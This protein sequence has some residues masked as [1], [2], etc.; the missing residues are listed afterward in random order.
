MNRISRWEST[1]AALLALVT[2]L[3][4]QGVSVVSP[5]AESGAKLT[6]APTTLSFGNVQI[7]PTQTQSDIP[8][9]AAPVA[10]KITQASAKG[11]GFDGDGGSLSSPTSLRRSATLTVQNTGGLNATIS[12]VTVAGKG[13]KISGIS[14]PWTLRPGQRVSF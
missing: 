4:C 14:T 11:T 6:V 1:I 2:M 12:Q 5:G 9:S 8:T 13:F 3:G 7:G 10:P